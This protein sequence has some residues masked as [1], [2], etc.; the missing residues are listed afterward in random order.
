MATVPIERITDQTPALERAGHEF[1]YRLAAGWCQG[2]SVLD[3]GRGTGHGARLLNAGHHT[4]VD[5]AKWF[6]PTNRRFGQFVNADVCDPVQ[7]L[8]LPEYEIAVAF[9]VLEHVI[10]PGQL[11]NL[12]AR[13]RIAIVSVPIVPTV[14]KN[15]YHL[16]D[17]TMFD[18]PRMFD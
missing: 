12:C 16:H 13:A 14:G 1:R 18:V 6:V 5:V 11:V 17:F 9:E 7:W 2:R 3:L 15:P 10:D 8:N 4:G